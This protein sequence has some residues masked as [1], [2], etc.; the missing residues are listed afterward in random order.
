MVAFTTLPKTG[1]SLSQ[2]IAVW[3]T[4]RRVTQGRSRIFPVENARKLLAENDEY[5]IIHHEL[6]A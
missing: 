3:R 2:G 1:A 6:S 5:V 4:I